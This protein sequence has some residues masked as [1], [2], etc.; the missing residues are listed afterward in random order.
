[1]A[2][3]S[4]VR[5][6]R[7]IRR[8]QRPNRNTQ[9]GQRPI[10]RGQRPN[11]STQGGRQSHRGCACSHPSL[12]ELQC[13]WPLLLPQ[14]HARAP[15]ADSAGTGD[16]RLPRRFV[17]YY[18]TQRYSAEASRT[19]PPYS[20]SQT[21]LPRL[22]HRSAA[23]HPPRPSHPSQRAIACPRMRRIRR[24]AP[25]PVPVTPPAQCGRAARACR[26]RAP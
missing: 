26:T 17:R 4:V 21:R 11:R 18:C 3:D 10:R 8:S 2:R 7:P 5:R 15:M 13:A 12:N 1:M 23:P 22:P 16:L 9:G 19:S 6:Q 25:L 20:T 14:Q 24:A